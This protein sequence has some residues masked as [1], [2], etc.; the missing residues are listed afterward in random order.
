MSYCNIT[1]D[2]DPQL[3]HYII[4]HHFLDESQFEEFGIYDPVFYDFMRVKH[5]CCSRLAKYNCHIM[6]LGE[7]CFPL[8]IA[9]RWGL[10]P[11]QRQRAESGRGRLPFDLSYHAT[12][13]ILEYIKNDFKYYHADCITT[14]DHKYV[15][16]CRNKNILFSH[17]YVDLSKTL[18]V[19]FATFNKELTER[20]KRFL[21]EI[22][23]YDNIIFIHNI[24]N[25]CNIDDV[26]SLHAIIKDKYNANIITLANDQMCIS[27]LGNVYK[28]V[29]NDKYD[30]YTG[31]KYLTSFGF[32]YEFRIINHILCYIED[33]YK[34]VL[35][36][37]TKMSYSYEYLYLRVV[38]YCIEV[39]CN[40]RG[41]EFF[42]NKALEYSNGI[43]SERWLQLA[44]KLSVLRTSCF[45]K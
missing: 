4:T 20:S 21:N 14:Y 42:L 15:F 36:Q 37:S 45:V 3:M 12:A 2:K 43:Y 31:V 22:N 33:N 11:T 8:T 35:Q 41:A 23:K 24:A 6:S 27:D 5:D 40:A 44:R 19:N 10:A 39:E 16:G 30:P 34:P 17:D 38:N 9:T 1:L 13:H 28:I 18:D 29:T 26:K 32:D 7:N 25:S